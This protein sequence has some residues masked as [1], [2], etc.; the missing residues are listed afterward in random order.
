M[1]LPERWKRERE[2]SLKALGMRDYVDYLASPLWA[3]IRKTVYARAAGKCE[4]SGCHNTATSVHHWSYALPTMRG[5]TIANLRALCDA[6]HRRAHG[7][8]KPSAKKQAKKERRKA[9]KEW[10]RSG[11]ALGQKSTAV[12][13]LVKSQ[14][15]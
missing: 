7:I 10:V 9:M 1:K 14:D 4:T 13:R 3:R 8:R 6:C 15:L 5:S 12:A 2:A 11:G